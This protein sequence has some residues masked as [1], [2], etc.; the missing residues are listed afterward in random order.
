MSARRRRHSAAS[1]ISDSPYYGIICLSLVAL[2]MPAPDQD[3]VWLRNGAIPIMGFFNQTI[4][5][6]APPRRSAMSA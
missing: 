5:G 4:A 3:D 2:M 1:S 6:A